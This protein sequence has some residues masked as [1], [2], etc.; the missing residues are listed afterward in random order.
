MSSFPCSRMVALLFPLRLASARKPGA[1][2]MQL[3]QAGGLFSS[4]LM[5]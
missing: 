4:E 1:P 2:L 5:G 3:Y